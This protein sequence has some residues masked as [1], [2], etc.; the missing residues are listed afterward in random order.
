MGASSQLPR[1]YMPEHIL[2]VDDNPVNVALLERILRQFDFQVEGVHSGVAALASLAR[3]T[4]AIIL[5]DVKMPDMDGFELLRQLRQQAE[6]RSIPVLLV[7]GYAAAED[8]DRAHDAG[9]DAVIAKPINARDLVARVRTLLTLRR[10]WRDR[11]AAEGV[12]CEWVRRIE[13]R[14]PYKAGHGER[15]AAGLAS[16]APSLEWPEEELAALPWAALAH[17]VGHL[18]T[19]EALL[20]RKG[21]LSAAERT[22]VEQHAPRGEEMCAALGWLPGASLLIR[23]HH[24]RWDG[25]GYPDGLR[26]EAIPRGARLLGMVDALDT[27]LMARPRHGAASLPQALARLD[28]ETA[29]G[30]WDPEMWPRVRQWALD[31]PKAV[32]A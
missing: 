16:L 30:W 20:L 14:A 10:A 26:G 17:D 29:R 24:E 2:V 6:T 9:A 1:H 5:L 15:V 25:S 32:G 4:P 27:L 31:G 23:H 21:R 13:A 18:G 8:H 7:T 19:P 3:R 28:E 22:L 11:E 12:L